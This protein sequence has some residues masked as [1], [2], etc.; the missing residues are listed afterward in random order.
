MVLPIRALCEIPSYRHT[1]AG[2]YPANKKTGLTTSSF[3]SR[4]RGN[5]NAAL[6][7][8][9]PK[10]TSHRE[11]RGKAGGMQEESEG[12]IMMTTKKSA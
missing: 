4:L 8:A 5:D 12:V 6:Y 9:L 2:G 1:R 10:K 3:S 7:P 11:S